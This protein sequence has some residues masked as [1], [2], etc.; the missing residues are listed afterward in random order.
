[1]PTG[2]TAPLLDGK[3]K[4]FRD[5]AIECSK[6]FG[7]YVEFRDTPV[8]VPPETLKVS[9]YYYKALEEAQ[10]AVDEVK[11]KKDEDLRKIYDKDL[12]DTKKYYTE[13]LEKDRQENVILD[14]MI[15]EVLKWQYPTP[16]HAGIRS[17]MLEQLELSKNNTKYYE[18]RLSEAFNPPSFSEWF[19]D[20]MLSI[21]NDL[22]RAKKNLEEQ[23]QRVANNNKWIATFRSSLPPA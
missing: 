2:Y 22:D 3:I 7:V 6:A 15:A 19:K 1:M 9:D 20:H 5:F 4:T 17:F 16:E 18:E 21:E 8:D 14:N 10:K 12:E 23:E 13:Q 11:D